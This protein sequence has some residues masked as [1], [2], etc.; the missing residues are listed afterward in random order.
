MGADASASAKVAEAEDYIATEPADEVGIFEETGDTDEEHNESF[1]EQYTM[2]L[3]AVGS[4]LAGVL[5]TL[6]A[7]AGAMRLKSNRRAAAAATTTDY[8]RFPGSE[9]SE[10]VV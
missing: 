2:P 6:G 7:V 3:I 5:A 10:S 1:F 8:Q 4:A 9:G